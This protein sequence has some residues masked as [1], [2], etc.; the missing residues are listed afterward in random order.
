[1]SPRHLYR[2]MR[3]LERKSRW[4]ST[5]AA[6]V[7]SGARGESWRMDYAAAEAIGDEADQTAEIANEYRRELGL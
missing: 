2:A 6:R 4:L 5:T 7:E 1:M 3:S